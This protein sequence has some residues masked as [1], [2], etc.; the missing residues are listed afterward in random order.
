MNIS[1]LLE[2]AADGLGDRPAVGPLNGG[3]SYTGLLARARKAARYFQTHDVHHVA[4]IGLN[5]PVVPLVLY[6]AALADKPFVPLNYRL[7]DEQLQ[8]ILKRIVPAVVVVD[9]AAPN[10]IGDIDGIEVI[11][12]D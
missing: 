4:L 10:R 9:S 12:Q 5:T 7:K 1:M 11:L 6:G 3:T 8:A 2:M